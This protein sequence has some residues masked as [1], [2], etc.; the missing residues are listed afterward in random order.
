MKELQNYNIQK[1]NKQ[2]QIELKVKNVSK[3]RSRIIHVRT[4]LKIIG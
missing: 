3:I 2:I 1:T 4:Y